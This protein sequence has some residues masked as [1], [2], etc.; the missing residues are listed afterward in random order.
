MTEQLSTTLQDLRVTD[1]VLN[2]RE[3]LIFISLKV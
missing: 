3:K 2:P 1:A